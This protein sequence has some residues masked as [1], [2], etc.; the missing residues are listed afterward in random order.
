MSRSVAAVARPG[1]LNNRRKSLLSLIL[2]LLS[3]R[4]VRKLRARYNLGRE[5]VAELS[6]ISG[7]PPVLLYSLLTPL[8]S[9]TAEKL[10]LL[11]QETRTGSLHRQGFSS[12][13]IADRLS[14]PVPTVR[15]HLEERFS[16]SV[17]LARPWYNDRAPDPEDRDTALYEESTLPPTSR[18]GWRDGSLTDLPPEVSGRCCVCGCRG[19]VHEGRCLACRV[20]MDMAE[21]KIPH[22]AEV[23]DEE[24]K[25]EREPDLLFF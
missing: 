9:R 8:W 12:E 15:E 23:S 1:K 7:C 17:F 20:R 4:Q 6:Q 14:L 3:P 13:E 24:E 22:A 19:Y 16:V 11:R 21:R 5:T 18:L 10:R 25:E 2:Q